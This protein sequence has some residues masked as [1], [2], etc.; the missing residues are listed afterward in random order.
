MADDKKKEPSAIENYL[1]IKKDL[2][3]ISDGYKTH[4]IDMYNTAAKAT[5][6]Y[7]P[8]NHRVDMTK[9]ENEE[10]AIK[11]ATELTKARENYIINRWSI[12][13]PKKLT[14]LEKDILKQ[15]AGYESVETLK[16]EILNKGKNYKME[17]F[18]ETL[19]QKSQE[20]DRQMYQIAGE[21][22]QEKDIDSIL[23]YTGTENIIDRS[24]VTIQQA[25]ALLA[26]SGDKPTKFDS[27]QVRAIL[28][29]NYLKKEDKK[30]K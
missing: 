27:E 3:Q 21:R 11:F 22:I 6:I 7:D 13:D 20:L 8:K 18:V 4:G 12:S 25:K 15:T 23:K 9:L 2:K 16:Q 19:V 5:G 14:E 24:K 26:N 29:K 10:T 30:P 28:G 17:N 1:T